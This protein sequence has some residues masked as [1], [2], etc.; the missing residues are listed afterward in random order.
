MCRMYGNKVIMSSITLTFPL[1]I[2]M[3]FLEPIDL[4]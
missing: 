2:G 1:R 3:K 4:L